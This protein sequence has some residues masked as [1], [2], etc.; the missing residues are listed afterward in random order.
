MCIVLDVMCPKTKTKSRTSSKKTSKNQKC[1][2]CTTRK[3]AREE[4]NH[5]FPPVSPDSM[6]PMAYLNQDQPGHRT[7]YNY[8][9]WAAWEDNYPAMITKKQ[10]GDYM[11]MASNT[12]SLSQDSRAKIGE[13]KNAITGEIKEAQK[14]IKDAHVDVNSMEARVRETRGAIDLAQASI[15]NTHVAINEAHLSIKKTQDAIQDNH[16]EYLSKQRECAA[17]V[18]RVRQLLEEEAKQREETRRLQEMVRYA[19]SQGLLQTPAQAQN[20]SIRDRDR[21]SRSSSPDTS[22]S[23]SETRGPSRRSRT[24]AEQEAQKRRQ[25]ERE[26]EKLEQYQQL[27]YSEAMRGIVD[28]RQRLQREQERWSRA[29]WELESLRRREL[30]LHSPRTQGMY[31][32]NAVGVPFH[33]ADTFVE[34]SLG[35]S[36]AAG[37]LRDRGGRAPRRMPP[38]RCR[39]WDH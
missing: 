33:D 6:A 18:A 13:A 24:N 39:Q 15:R 3:I 16:A 8:E 26:R 27:Q 30:Y 10:W 9:D 25:W 35:N 4:V 7:Y 20:Q 36:G 32:D 34:N 22:A 23:S 19:Q 37:H 38:G 2:E 11:G 12:Y 17:D 28:T 31:Y 14:A 1:H 5:M 29:E 21:S